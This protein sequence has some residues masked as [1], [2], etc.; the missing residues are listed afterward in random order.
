MPMARARPA[1]GLPEGKKGEKRRKI[2]RDADS[3]E[4][5]QQLFSRLQGNVDAYQMHGNK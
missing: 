4:P 5:R 2:G 3:P 1:P